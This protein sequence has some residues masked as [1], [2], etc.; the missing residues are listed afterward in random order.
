M[1]VEP[2]KLDAAAGLGAD[3]GIDSRTE[4]VAARVRDLTEG[5]GADV[6]IEAVGATKPLLTAIGAVRKGGTVTV[7]GNLSPETTLPL[8][9]VVTRQIRLQG[10]CASSGE[11]PACIALLAAGKIRVDPILSAVAPLADGPAWFDRLYGKEPGLMKVVLQ[12]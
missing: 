1:D 2:A 3:V 7:I 12:P 6:A 11:Y 5:R 4:D 9:S 10:S 8:Q